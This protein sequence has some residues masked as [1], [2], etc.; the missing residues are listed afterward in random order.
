MDLDF[1]E[2]TFSGGKITT[3]GDS[4][5]TVLPTKIRLANRVGAF[6]GT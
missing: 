4:A 5:A 2:V 3:F 6:L 1:V